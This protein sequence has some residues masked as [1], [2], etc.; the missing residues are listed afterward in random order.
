MDILYNK[1]FFLII[2]LS[3]SF[4]INFQFLIFIYSIKQSLNHL[5]FISQSIIILVL[6]FF[7]FKQK[8]VFI[9][10]QVYRATAQ[11][12]LKIVR[13]N[14]FI[15]FFTPLNVLVVYNTVKFWL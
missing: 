10:I 1:T 9:L 7:L 15:S 2:Y 11:D 6:F 8:N 13:G 12:F 4:S 14:C 5:L 3:I